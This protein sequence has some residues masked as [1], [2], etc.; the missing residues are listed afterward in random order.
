MPEY[1]TRTPV[2]DHV[3]EFDPPPSISLYR[4]Q[5]FI[6]ILQQICNQILSA[7]T[8]RGQIHAVLHFNV[9]RRRIFT[10][11]FLCE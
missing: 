4:R 3:R 11:F 2:C 6:L 8:Y 10:F 9:Y 7:V 1:Q 5:I